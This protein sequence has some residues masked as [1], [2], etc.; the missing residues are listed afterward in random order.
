MKQPPKIFTVRETAGLLGLTVDGVQREL[1]EGRLGAIQINS[2]HRLVPLAA[3]NAWLQDRYAH[4]DDVAQLNP[5]TLEL[6]LIQREP[7]KKVSALPA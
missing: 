7:G 3:V 2:K 4:T 1:R 5:E 6:E